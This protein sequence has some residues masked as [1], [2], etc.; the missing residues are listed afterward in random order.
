MLV[1]PELDRPTIKHRGGWRN[2][3]YETSFLVLKE[4]G[5]IK[6]VFHIYNKK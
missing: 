2:I 4:K 3:I 1:F 6:K 5:L